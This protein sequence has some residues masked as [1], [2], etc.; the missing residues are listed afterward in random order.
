MIGADTS[1]LID[2][3]KGEEDAV[4]RMKKHQ[5]VLHL[6][7]NVVYEFLCGNLR[8]EERE[9]FLAFV[10]QFPVFSFDREA[11][12][13]SSKIFRRGKEIGKP[14]P[15]PDAM[16]AGIYAA[17]EVDK[18]ITRNPEHFKGVKEITVI[19]Y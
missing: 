5:D 14:I 12:L 1:F 3:L 16:I 13:R 6:C 7:E 18:I 9:V 2:F 15:H 11:A 4:K 8:E 19:E 10:S 17:H